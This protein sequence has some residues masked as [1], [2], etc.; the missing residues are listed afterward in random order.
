MSEKIREVTALFGQSELDVMPMVG[1]TEIEGFT[2]V[3]EHVFGSESDGYVDVYS[4]SSAGNVKVR[5]QYE[6]M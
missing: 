4:G 5:S 2:L 6:W 3:E 1:V